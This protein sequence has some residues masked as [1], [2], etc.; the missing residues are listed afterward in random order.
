MIVFHMPPPELLF[1]LGSILFITGI[2]RLATRRRREI[3]VKLWT[4]T[5][6]EPDWFDWPSWGLA[7]G[8][9]E[10]F[11]PHGERERCAYVMGLR[12]AA[13][14]AESEHFIVTPIG[15][16]VKRDGIRPAVKAIHRYVLDFLKL[17]AKV[18]T[19]NWSDDA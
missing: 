14:I 16:H 8:S 17:P 19:D 10:R 6:G 13:R 12:D 15:R 7:I 2:G 5:P 18:Q 9:D 4:P 1:V 3:R 11:K